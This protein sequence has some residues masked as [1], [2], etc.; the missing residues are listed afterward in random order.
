MRIVKTSRSTNWLQHYRLIYLTDTAR[1]FR[2]KHGEKSKNL[3][4]NHNQKTHM[5]TDMHRAWRSRVIRWH[6]GQTRALRPLIP[7]HVSQRDQAVWPRT[8]HENIK[9][10]LRSPDERWRSFWEESKGTT[11]PLTHAGFKL[12]EDSVMFFWLIKNR[13]LNNS[14][15]KSMRGFRC[16]ASPQ[17]RE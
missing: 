4:R 3:K 10:L 6:Q 2:S 11:R 12:T 1:Q 15:S 16:S 8:K 17:N 5:P 14:V 13:D 9:D 7:F